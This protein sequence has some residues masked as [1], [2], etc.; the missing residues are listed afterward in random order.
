MDEESASRY[1]ALAHMQRQ[2]L[3]VHGAEE[4]WDSEWGP[5][6]RLVTG[7]SVLVLSLPASALVA[8]AVGLGPGSPLPGIL[9]GLGTLIGIPAVVNIGLRA[10]QEVLKRRTQ[11]DPEWL[12]VLERCRLLGDVPDPV[13]V[14]LNRAL[15]A[16]ISMR[17]VA[18]DPA[19]RRAGLPASEFIRQA[20]ARVQE[21]LEWGRRLKFI[22]G[23]LQELPP[24]GDTLPEYREV[25]AQYHLQC[26]NL[27]RAADI[28]RQAEAKMTRA[29]AAL[30]S[31]QSL[32]SAVADQFQDA[33]ATFDALAEIA[34]PPDAWSTPRIAASDEEV[35]QVRLGG[36]REARG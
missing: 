10:A 6:R 8:Q 27:S 24:A 22:A 29:Y 28:F 23:R 36:S 13:A 17:R 14:S 33:T 19:W 2:A 20:G 1:P 35:Q 4:R 30:S 32:G 34:A 21:L 3:H 31:N 25:E 9:A 11:V 5:M 7:S 18:Q 16:Y 12:Q 26:E 15:D